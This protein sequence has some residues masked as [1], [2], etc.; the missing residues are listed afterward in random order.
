MSE[1]IE[2]KMLDEV[3][4]VRA[5]FHI[6]KFT[7]DFLWI[8]NKIENK[9]LAISPSYQRT[10]EWSVKKQSR[11]IESLILNMPIPP[12]YIVEDEEGKWELLD[13]LQRI[14][15][16]IH[17]LGKID[18]LSINK[19][20][21]NQSD[22]EG[23]QDSENLDD[24][25]PFSD[26]LVLNDCDIIKSLNGKDKSSIETSILNRICNKAID[27]YL[28]SYPGKNGAWMRYQMFIRI[29]SGGQ[30]LSNQQIRNA[31]IRLLD[32]QLINF[33]N[34][35]LASNESFRQTIKFLKSEDVMQ[36]NKGMVFEELVLR[37][38][39]FK[40]DRSNYAKDI[41]PFLDK[42]LEKCAKKE[43]PFDYE[44]E[45]EIFNKT[46]SFLLER[47]NNQTFKINSKSNH[48]L[49]ETFT[50]VI[51]DYLNNSGQLNKIKHLSSE[52]L[53][54]FPNSNF[55]DKNLFVGGGKNTR[56]ML[57]QRISSFKNYLGT[58][59]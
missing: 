26:S 1:K 25:E 8:I 22:D 36:I 18:L 4:E 19:L 39:A 37:F 30:T 47:S 2:K 55:F 44:Q 3:L 21:L 17:F 46:F 14:S 42:Y 35:K 23:F 11:F 41:A 5:N 34:D 49:Y 54:N 27:V 45:E 59:L 12:I 56:K 33:I 51:A 16:F 50:L 28:F 32:N 10:F 57:D 20:Q 31:A 15:T 24:V 7:Y 9:Q 40:N 58:I 48:N 13:G 6:E 38:L 29:N 52:Q 53:N 43:A